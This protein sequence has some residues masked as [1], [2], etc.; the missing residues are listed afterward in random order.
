[1]ES[2]HTQISLP[3]PPTGQHQ[4]TGSTTVT[5]RRLI[6]VVV[7]IVTG[8][9][10]GIAAWLTPATEGHGTHE[11][12]GLQPCSWVARFDMP[13]P[14]CGMTTAFTH[15][16]NGNFVQSFTTQPMGFI[17][18]VLTAAGF[19]LSSYVAMTG[20]TIGAY[21]APIWNARTVWILVALFLAAW[22]YKIV[23]F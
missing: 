18:V 10:L 22:V 3:H 15:A 14:T 6:G 8:T 13:C 2:D 11:Q 23:T 19:L 7:M 5:G 1:M 16:A 4:M 12:L 20:S 21:F 9:I 17:L